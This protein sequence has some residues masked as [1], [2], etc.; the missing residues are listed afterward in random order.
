M[1]RQ[2]AKT[3]DSID[4]QVGSLVRRRRIGLGMSQAWLAGLL[5]VTFQ[6]VQKYEQ[7]SNR[8]SAGRLHAIA[9]AL[10]V[11]VSFLF[12]VDAT[13]APGNAVEDAHQTT[14][15]LRLNRAF[16]KI[17]NPRLRS[18]VVELVQSIAESEGGDGAA[19]KRVGH[20]DR[21]TGD[22]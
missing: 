3:V 4:V 16:F 6:Q 15:A 21:I 2:D 10:R 11:S 22:R 20:E 19:S 17:D 18:H 14:E 5:G 7:G 12:G 8:I 1:K 9:D 13:T